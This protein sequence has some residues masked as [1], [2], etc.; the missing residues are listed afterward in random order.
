MSICR[1]GSAC[2]ASVHRLYRH[3]KVFGPFPLELEAEVDV[4][5]NLLGEVAPAQ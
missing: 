1:I 3:F 2:K 5:V 4:E